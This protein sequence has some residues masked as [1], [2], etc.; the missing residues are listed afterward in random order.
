VRR[1]WSF[2][3]AEIRQVITPFPHQKHIVDFARARDLALHVLAG[4]GE[5]TAPQLSLNL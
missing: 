3:I 4:K 2:S 1:R 5:N